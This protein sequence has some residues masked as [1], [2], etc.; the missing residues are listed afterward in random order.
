[1]VTSTIVKRIYFLGFP[2]RMRF[3]VF[4]S[5]YRVLAPFRQLK[6]ND[7]KSLDDCK[8]I[9]ACLSEQLDKKI[10]KLPNVSFKY[11]FGKRHIFLRYVEWVRKNEHSLFKNRTCFYAKK[12]EQSKLLQTWRGH[13]FPAV[14]TH[15]LNKPS[16]SFKEEHN[17]FV[18]LE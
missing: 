5:R 4:N 7:D 14:P 3:K 9:L 15:S 1:M 18:R 11:D 2:H 10:Y 17:F 16:S 8:L 13:K 12:R 6:R